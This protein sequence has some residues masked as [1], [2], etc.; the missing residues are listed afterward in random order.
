M[1]GPS[2]AETMKF[3][4]LMAP[5]DIVATATASEY[6]AVKNSNWLSFIVQFM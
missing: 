1:N 6:M 4:P 2:F 3:L 5:K